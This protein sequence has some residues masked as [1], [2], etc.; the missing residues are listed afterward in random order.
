MT[1]GSS[2]RGPG[3][4]RRHP[5]QI[6]RAGRLACPHRGTRGGLQNGCDPHLLRYQHAIGPYERCIQRCALDE[7][8]RRSGRRSIWRRGPSQLLGT[9]RSLR[10]QHVRGCQRLAAYLY[11]HNTL[12]LLAFLLPTRVAGAHPLHNIGDGMAEAY[13]VQAL[14][15]HAM[16]VN[17]MR[18]NAC[19]L[20]VFDLGLWNALD[21]AWEEI[22]AL[23]ATK[24]DNRMTLSA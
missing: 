9:A 12:D 19:A 20:G 4:G 11:T 23:L 24:T 21:V 15:A 5:R 6:P 2:G 22:I 7:C 8:G 1:V 3:R 10:P 13:N 18:R 14:L 16:T 17:G